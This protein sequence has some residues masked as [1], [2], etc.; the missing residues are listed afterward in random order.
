ML[1]SN[2]EKEGN[3]SGKLNRRNDRNDIYF[4]HDTVVRIVS[5]GEEQILIENIRLGGYRLDEQGGGT[6]FFSKKGVLSHGV[7]EKVGCQIARKKKIIIKMINGNGKSCQVLKIFHWNKG[8]GWW[9]NKVDEI[10]ILIHEKVPDMLFISEANLRS[11][12]S[13]KIKSFEGY[14]TEHP[15][16]SLNLGYSR[17]VLLIHSNIDYRIL[18]NY[19]SDSEASIWV[20][21]IIEGRRPIVVGGNYR[22]HKFLLQQQPNVSGSPALQ[23]K[24]W[25]KTVEGWAAA[26]ADNSRCFFIGDLNLDY[27]RWEMP[28]AGHVKMV[29]KVKSEIETQGLCQVIKG[30]TRFWPGQP[31]SQ[32]DHCWTNSPWTS[33]E[34]L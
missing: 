1:L 17:L 6:V 18:N 34:P 10:E 11:G 31:P 27:S 20:K 33:N 19:M 14:I 25:S 7:Q 16:T 13:D 26:A 9:E 28:E 21:I 15:K 4:V 30:M 8:H 22:E 12:I 29:N 2:M 3:S 32:V 24:R 5:E 23:Q